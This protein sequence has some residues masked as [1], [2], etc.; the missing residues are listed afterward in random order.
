MLSNYGLFYS[1]VV[2]QLFQEKIMKIYL[3]VVEIQL[4]FVSNPTDFNR[5]ISELKQRTTLLCDIQEFIL[6]EPFGN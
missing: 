3:Q 5:T 2:R 6:I 1:I 4:I